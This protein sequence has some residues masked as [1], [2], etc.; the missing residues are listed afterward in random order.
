MSHDSAPRPASQ[1]CLGQGS[2]QGPRSTV[3][4]P[5][6]Y[7][8]PAVRENLIGSMVPRASRGHKQTVEHSSPTAVTR[9][10]SSVRT[11]IAAEDDFRERS[12]F[13]TR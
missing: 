5:R 8:S 4:V 7:L 3:I 10:W 12:T 2:H 6:R 9:S 11:I 13:W 1:S